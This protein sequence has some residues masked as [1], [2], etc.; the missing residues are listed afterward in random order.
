MPTQKNIASPET[1][2]QYFEQYRQHTKANPKKYHHWS[3]RLEKQVSV[4]REIPLTWKGFEIWLRQQGIIAKLDDYEAN[5]DSRYGEYAAIIRAIKDEI[6]DD[7]FT[8]AAVGVFQH[9]IIAR[10]LG[11]MERTDHTTK[12][13]KVEFPTELKI[14]RVNP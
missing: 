7:K 9:N 10:D 4:D 2:Y 1:L 5:K 8:G 3:N 13:E 11:L 12:G 6:Y 14:V